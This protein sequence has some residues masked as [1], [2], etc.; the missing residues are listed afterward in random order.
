[1]SRDH[2]G[3]HKRSVEPEL[4]KQTLQNC[5]KQTMLIRHCL[6]MNKLIKT[7][8]RNLLCTRNNE[9]LVNIYVNSA[10][11]FPGCMNGKQEP[12]TVRPVTPQ[13]KW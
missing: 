6:L 1:M 13:E 4:S 7:N 11:T 9:V 10:E 2:R 8:T 3:S 5:N 12:Q